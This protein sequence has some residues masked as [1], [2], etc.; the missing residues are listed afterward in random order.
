MPDNKIAD[1]PLY[2]GLVDLDVLLESSVELANNGFSALDRLKELAPEIAQQEI[3][4][5]CEQLSEK[6]NSKLEEKNKKR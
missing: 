4:L 2:Q 6:I 1:N 5:I 3:D